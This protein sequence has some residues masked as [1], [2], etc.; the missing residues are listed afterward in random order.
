MV[1]Q[2]IDQAPSSIDPNLS[3][4]SEEKTVHLDLPLK[5]KVEQVKSMLSPLDPTLSL[6]GDNI[7]VVTMTQSSYHPTHPVESELKIVDVFLVSSD[8]SRQGGTMYTST[9]TLQVLRPFPLIWMF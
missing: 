2:M 5:N 8:C 1:D 6:E 4:K 7:E 9:G 3:L